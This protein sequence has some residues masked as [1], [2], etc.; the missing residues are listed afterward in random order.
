MGFCNLV[1]SLSVHVVVLVLDFSESRCAQGISRGPV[2]D[3]V[4][5][6]VAFGQDSNLQL[7]LL[8]LH[9]I[10]SLKQELRHQGEGLLDSEVTE[11]T[12]LDLVSGEL[13]SATSST[14]VVLEACT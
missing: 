10:L 2:K 8:L 7:L 6:V 14:S 12:L 11:V 4:H 13:A 3:F 5:P 9:F 1:T